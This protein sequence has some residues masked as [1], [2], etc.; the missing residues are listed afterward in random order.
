MISGYIRKS[1]MREANELKPWDLDEIILFIAFTLVPVFS[2]LQSFIPNLGEILPDGFVGGSVAALIIIFIVRNVKKINRYSILVL[3]SLLFF[4]LISS[5]NIENAEQITK[6]ITNYSYLTNY[7]FWIAFATVSTPY[8]FNTVLEK[9]SYTVIVVNTIK[10]L[11]GGYAISSF[12][13]D[14]ENM[15]FGFETIIYWAILTQSS[16]QKRTPFN[17]LIS[18]FSG[19]LLV[20][21]G[22]RGIL[23]VIVI[24]IFVYTLIYL[25]IKKKAL[26]FSIITITGLFL[27]AFYKNIMLFFYNIAISMGMNSRNIE[28][29]LASNFFDSNGRSDIWAS[30][31]ELIKNNPFF[32]SGIGAD[33]VASDGIYS[34]NLFIELLVNYGVFGGT[35]ISI[36]ILTLGLLMLFGKIDLEWKRLFVPFYLVGFTILQTS[37]SIYTMREFGIAIMIFCSYMSYKRCRSNKYRKS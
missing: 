29:L 11:T 23:L 18:I 26:I 2:S 32:G 24:T 10:L 35:L 17:V 3:F 5:F 31:I 8:R 4:I 22:N 13:N 9:I 14:V 27:I 7:L 12:T 30:D 6:I 15:A 28:M 37:Q 16:F 1:K 36:A 34:H 25:N 19:L 20:V 33:R 21:Y